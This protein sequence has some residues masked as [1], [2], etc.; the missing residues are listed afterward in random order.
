MVYVAQKQKKVGFGKN[1]CKNLRISK[2]TARGH[3]GNSGAPAQLQTHF[4]EDTLD[5]E[6]FLV[7]I[8]HHQTLNLFTSHWV[9]TVESN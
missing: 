8:Y 2:R 3:L 1:Y 9:H 7:N 5:G 4:F 6:I